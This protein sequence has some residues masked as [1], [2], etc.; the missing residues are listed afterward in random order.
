MGAPE[1]AVVMPV[2]NGLPHLDASVASV[3]AQTH[4]D[5]QLVVLDNGSTD[6]SAER[7]EHWAGEDQRIELHHH[8][9]RLGG[10]GSS[11]A[12]VQLTRAAIVAR[13]DADDICHPSRLER[14]LAVMHEH[15][16]ATMV[17]TLHC[18]LDAKG[19]RVRGR[20]RW[21]LAPGRAA[22]PFPG[23]SV[24]FRRRSYDEVGG[25]RKVDGMWEDLDL[26]VR[27]ARSGTA[28]VI[29]EAL[30]MYRV[31]HA[32]RTTSADAGVAVRGAV[33]RAAA[34]APGRT[35]PAEPSAAALFELN[36]LQL[37]A[38]GPPAHLGELR[39]VARR[40]PAR[41]RLVLL[42]W[43]RWARASPATLRAALRLRSA[44]RDRLAAPWYPTAKPR[45]WR[46]E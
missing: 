37:W 30:Y 8:A 36:S 42:I 22:M 2:H 33:A 12:V 4:S 23:G 38:G 35:R 40:S 13:M 3:L 46:P 39:R 15:P 16:E 9:E 5:F 31:H 17:A 34:F 6:G 44:V 32:S 41:R 1:L 19:R 29:P 26:C 25:Y 14:Q 7:L 21:A 43:A 45:E 18:Y 20:D 10:A 27:L 11:D 28:L 24:M